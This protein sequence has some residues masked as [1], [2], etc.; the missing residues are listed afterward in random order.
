MAL[1]EQCIGATDEWYTPPHVF[2]KLGCSFDLDVSSP[3]AAVE[4]TEAELKSGLSFSDAAAKILPALVAE[5]RAVVFNGNNY[6]EAW[7]KEA[8]ERG[9]KNLKTTPDALPEVLAED[10]V[11]AFEAYNVLSK[12]E[13]ESRY[14]VETV[15]SP[16]GVTHLTFTRR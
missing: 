6:D 7:H 16:S 14:E 5:V 15:A 1:H 3:G 4:Y 13:L 10:T 8:E 12:R 11:A 9:L 2:A